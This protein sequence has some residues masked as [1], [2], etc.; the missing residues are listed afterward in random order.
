MLTMLKAF[1]DAVAGTFEKAWGEPPR[2]SR[3]VHGVGIVSLGFFMD[4]V[5]D[6]MTGSR[7]D[8]MAGFVEALTAIEDDC[9]WTQGYWQLAPDDRRRWN[10][11]Q[12][13]PRDI[14]RLSAHLVWL[15]H[16]AAPINAA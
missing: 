3:L 10:E 4:T 16:A 11:L 15:Y 5:G 6:T 2:R 8:L 12:N 9:A 14:Q 7:D 1:W 13:T